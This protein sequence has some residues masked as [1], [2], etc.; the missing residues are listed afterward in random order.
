MESRRKPVSGSWPARE[1]VTASGD[2]DPEFMVVG[3]AGQES[4]GGDSAW[5]GW[6]GEDCAVEGG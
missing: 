5:R 4:G 1:D 3:G 6:A 2:D